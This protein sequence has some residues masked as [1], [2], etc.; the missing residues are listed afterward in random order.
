MEEEIILGK[1]VGDHS[2]K[3]PESKVIQGKYV[4][5]EPFNVE[6]QY[7]SLYYNYKETPHIW[8]YAFEH[9]PKSLEDYH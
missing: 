3:Y 1:K 5:L 6:K 9:P 2:A 4:R 8:D 7:E